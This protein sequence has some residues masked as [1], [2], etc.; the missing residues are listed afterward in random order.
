LDIIGAA[1]RQLPFRR[2]VRIGITGLARA[3][4]TA[5]LTSIAANLLAR[6]DIAVRP[7]P[8]GAEAMPRFDV[9]AHVAA[10][11]GDPPR[12]PARTDAVSLLVLDIDVPRP[13]LPPRR[14]RLELLDYPGEW[15]LD[16]PLL[17]RGFA[18]WSATTLRRLE[19]QP[20]AA[21]F[22]AFVHGLPAGAADEA[23][24]RTGTGLYRDLLHRLREE[25]GLSLLQPG[26]FLMPPPG[27]SPPWM[28]FFPM[29]GGSP[30]CWRGAT[31]AMCRRSG[32]SWPIRVSCV[33]IGWWC[34]PTC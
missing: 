2:T 11:A 9:Q 13:P 19:A 30:G 12:W 32:A 14:V 31:T 5:L 4:K 8:A 33:W 18:D 6:R 7:A 24:A 16:L 20:A 1:R 21:P 25:A 10:L 34:W 15:L 3:G 28:A 17:G 27:P 29:V 22:L 26:R 23:L